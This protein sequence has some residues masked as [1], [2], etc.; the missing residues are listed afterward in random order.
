[1][2]S[3]TKTF[4]YYVLIASVALAM[5]VT[6]V[7]A[8]EDS[9]NIVFNQ[10]LKCLKLP[11]DAPSAYS[12]LIVAVIKDGSADFLSVNFRTPPSEWEKTAAPLIADAI[13]ECE[14]YSS[15]SGRMEF[16]VTR[17]LIEAGSKN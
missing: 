11:A 4:F 12:F 15:I 13:T 7:L 10:M 9:G 5:N 16:A 14:P 2:H 8:S 17:E 1:M 3:L 6:S